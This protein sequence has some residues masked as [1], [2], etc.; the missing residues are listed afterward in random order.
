[1]GHL[2]RRAI[3]A[4]NSDDFTDLL[5]TECVKKLGRQVPRL[6]SGSYRPAGQDR[7]FGRNCPAARETYQGREKCIGGLSAASATWPPSNRS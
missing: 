4:L 2:D 7:Q 5:R 1:M 3:G 6:A